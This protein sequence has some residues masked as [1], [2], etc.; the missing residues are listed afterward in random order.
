MTSGN[1]LI[2][3]ETEDS[4]QALEATSIHSPTEEFSP[5]IQSLEFK[6]DERGLEKPVELDYD[7][8]IEM[9]EE[10]IK[11]TGTKVL[12]QLNLDEKPKFIKKI[13]RTDADKGGHGKIRYKPLIAG[14]KITSKFW[15]FLYYCLDH[16]AKAAARVIK[17]PLAFPPTKNINRPKLADKSFGVFGPNNK[18]RRFCARIFRFK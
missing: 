15:K 18:L 2:R 12:F 17:L 4:I 1:P 5:L 8:Y 14:R 9:E 6:M 11:K 10:P 7:K 16:S 13:K 3:S